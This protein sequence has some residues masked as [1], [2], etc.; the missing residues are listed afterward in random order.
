MESNGGKQDPWLSAVFVGPE[1]KV[2]TDSR[3]PCAYALWKL[4]WF[5]AAGRELR[6]KRASTSAKYEVQIHGE[7]GETGGWRNL[8]WS[9]KSQGA[10]SRDASLLQW[11]HP[12]FKSTSVYQLASGC[13]VMREDELF[14]NEK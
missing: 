10:H 13:V 6:L 14:F 8:K 4:N 9:V 5:S 2:E 7:N 3:I 11:G 1:G 12:G